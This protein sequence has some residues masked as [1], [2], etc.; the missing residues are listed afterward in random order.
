MF[1]TEGPT[2]SAERITALEYASNN[3]SSPAGADADG[4]TTGCWSVE[5]G[6][7]RA[8]PE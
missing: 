7:R 5:T 8:A 6:A 1:T 2:W 3:A 4:E